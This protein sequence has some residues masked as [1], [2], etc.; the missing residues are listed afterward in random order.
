MIL[1]LDNFDSFTYNLQD[2]FAQLGVSCKVYR[3][4]RSLDEITRDKYAAV[5]LSP[6]PGKPNEAGCL[7][8][9]IK[10][11]EKTHPILGICLGHQAVGIYYGAALRRANKPMHGKTS[12]ISLKSDILFKDIHNEQ[13]VVRYH[14]LVLTDLP[15]VLKVTARTQTGEVMG[16]AHNKLPIHGLQFHPEAFL[17]K[18]GLKMLH[19]WV[20]FYKL[21]D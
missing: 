14:S 8:Q 19:N 6:G 17:T 13:N 20:S 4:D 11:Y 12:T 18:E 2:Y 15:E 3:N 7:M 16:I 10:F 9:V 1:I 5:V 21:A